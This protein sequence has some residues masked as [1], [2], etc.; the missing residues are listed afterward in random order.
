MPDDQRRRSG[1][2]HLPARLSTGDSPVCDLTSRCRHA[3][4]SRFDGNVLSASG[5]HF[6]IRSLSTTKLAIRTPILVSGVDDWETTSLASIFDFARDI[7]SMLM[8][9]SALGHVDA[10]SWR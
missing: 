5:T 1:S 8:N 2:L 3:H 10:R 9:G 4:P 7:V 6:V